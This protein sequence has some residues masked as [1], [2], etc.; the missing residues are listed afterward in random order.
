MFNFKGKERQ[1]DTKTLKVLGQNWCKKYEQDCYFYKQEGEDGK[2]Y[3]LTG[4][5]AVESTFSGASP[6][7][8]ADMYFTMLN[9]SRKKKLSK[10]FTFREGIVYLAKSPQTLAEAYS[11]KGEIFFNV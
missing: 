2:G 8:A 9:K 5:G 4:T 10:S 7:K 6:T 11:R 3:Y 1:P